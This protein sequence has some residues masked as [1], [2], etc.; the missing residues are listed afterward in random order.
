MSTDPSKLTNIGN[1][2]SCL[3]VLLVT[4]TGQRV[5][6]YGIFRSYIPAEHYY[7]ETFLNA[8]HYRQEQPIP[9]SHSC[10]C[11]ASNT[12]PTFPFLL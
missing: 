12:M 4:A 7:V 8:Q 11:Q 5:C 3:I 10:S 1:I 6:S 9:F 2:Y